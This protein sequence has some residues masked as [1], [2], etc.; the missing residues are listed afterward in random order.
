MRHF[1]RG[2]KLRIIREKW[3]LFSYEIVVVELKLWTLACKNE[4]F[5]Y[6]IKDSKLT[7]PDDWIVTPSRLMTRVTS[8]EI[9]GQEIFNN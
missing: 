7:L 9:S 8:V 1:N 6:W 2:R 4:V 5:L 3:F